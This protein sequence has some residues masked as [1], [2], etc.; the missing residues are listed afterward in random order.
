ML[1]SLS[2]LNPALVATSSHNPRATEPDAIVELAAGTEMTAQAAS[3][4][5][6][7]LALAR[8]LAGP[9]GVVCVTGSLYVVAEAREALGLAAT[10]A[11]E[12]TLLYR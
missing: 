8:A 1:R 7:A 2:R 5:P 6:D 3:D 11:S 10:P 4:L 12:R 9:D